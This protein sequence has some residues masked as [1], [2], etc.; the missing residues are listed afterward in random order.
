MPKFFTVTNTVCVLIGGFVVGTI[1]YV[2]TTTYQFGNEAPA[3]ANGDSPVHVETSSGN[4]LLKAS[5]ADVARWFPGTCFAEIYMKN[6]SYKGGLIAGCID[7]TSKEI[8]AET[9]ATLGADDFRTPEVLTHFKSVYG[10]SNP[11][12]T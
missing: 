8:K 11:W 1:I 4:P 2:N 9:G 6:P 10:A 5:K 12:R 7:K 3:A